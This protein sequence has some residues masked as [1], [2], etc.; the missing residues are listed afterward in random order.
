[1]K[2]NVKAFDEMTFD[3]FCENA[4]ARLLQSIDKGDFKF[5]FHLIIDQAYK[6]GYDNAMR[7]QCLK[8]ADREK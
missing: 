5:T 3:E 4:K 1:M 8:W 6:N 2:N 7:Q